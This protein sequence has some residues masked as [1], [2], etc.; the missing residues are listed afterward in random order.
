MI[1]WCLSSSGTKT[2]C[3][4]SYLVYQAASLPPL[5]PCQ[6]SGLTPSSPMGQVKHPPLERKYQLIPGCQ[7]YGGTGMAPR[8]G[9]MASAWLCGTP[10]GNTGS[11]L[12]EF[13]LAHARLPGRG[14]G[15]VSPV[16]QP[17]M[18]GRETPLLRV[19]GSLRSSG[20]GCPCLLA[21]SLSTAIVCLP[22]LLLQQPLLLAG[23]F[24]CFSIS[25]LCL[26]LVMS[27]LCF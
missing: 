12:C 9:V 17:C 23:L 22:S 8:F 19:L 26:F 15:T 10:E 7:G 21:M 18:V 4:S 3:S 16:C 25:A 24:L 14:V 6:T 13:H 1:C 20:S 11:N 27:V 5:Q 2:P